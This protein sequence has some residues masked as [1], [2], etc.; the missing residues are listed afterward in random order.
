[1]NSIKGVEDHTKKKADLYYAETITG[2]PQVIH[3][4]W[5][6]QL[7]KNHQI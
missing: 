4:F 7:L 2:K 3:K 6:V 1:M 5:Y